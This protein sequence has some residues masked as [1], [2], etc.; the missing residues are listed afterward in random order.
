[1]AKG[2]AK[3]NNTPSQ[4]RSLRST[5]R[6]C[7]SDETSGT[8]ATLHHQV[9]KDTEGN[10]TA[11]DVT[12]LQCNQSP[13]EESTGISTQQHQAE[14]QSCITKQDP[15]TEE[16][17]AEAANVNLRNV[18]EEQEETTVTRPN[19]DSQLEGFRVHTDNVA[20]Q[21][22]KDKEE[23]TAEEGNRSPLR[24]CTDQLQVLL[25]TSE[26]ADGSCAT[27]LE[28]QLGAKENSQC[29]LERNQETS[30]V[31][32]AD[33]KEVTKEAAVGLPAKKKRRMGM[34]GLTE[35]ERSHFLQTQK[36]ENG[37]NG[38]ERVEL[39]CNNTAGLV[40]QEEISSP[41]LSSSL[42]IPASS[43]TE[44]EEE[45]LKLQSSH[46]GGND[47]AET[48]DHMAVTTST[49]TSTECDPGCSKVKSCEAEGGTV[50][51][52]TKSDPPA[53]EVLLGNDEQQEIQQGGA[54]EI[55]AEKPQEQTKEGEYGSA[56][57]VQSP[58][59]SFYSNPTQSEG[60]ENQD[61]IQAAPLHV[62]NVT[63]TRDEK[64]E[65]LTDDAGDGNRAE[66]AASS[67]DTRSGLL[68]CGSGEL[69]K[70][71]VT[72]SGSER[73]DSKWCDPDDEPGPSTLNTEHP[74]TVDTPDPF[75]SGYLDYVSDSQLNTISLAEEE[76][77]EGEEDL[78]YPDCP[79]ATDLIC[80]LI[81]ELSSI[82][83]K[84]MA[85]HRELENL[86]RSDKGSKS[87]TR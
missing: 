33:I 64:K 66:A 20:N 61:E 38:P 4:P 53:E 46:C 32:M 21:R 29:D 65:E 70:A 43:V 57:V 75:G 45:L 24:T 44:Q 63:R 76:V 7:P 79:D 56:V 22:G 84:V 15:V 35:K 16:K 50:P 51:G 73:K 10:N 39:I 82:N 28:E 3:K 77:M 31:N 68:N 36:R 9:I 85:T 81:R 12:M 6:D 69:C 26:E 30:N 25:P 80:G 41:S 74:Q 37:L 86:R 58:A 1:M 87:S 13:L 2:K 54:A 71:A 60:A 14:E 8:D 47:R 11:V 72:P 5:K 48:E 52:D 78:G 62:N 34:C 40:P 55:V 59:I 17:H 42:S 83:Q 49:G 18:V 19:N 67:T 27:A 23:I